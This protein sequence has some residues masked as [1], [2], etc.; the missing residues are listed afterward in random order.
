MIKK[1]KIVLP[2][3]CL[4]I[5]SGCEDLFVRFKNERYECKP[6][7]VNLNKIFIKNYDQGDEVDVEVGDYLYKFK[8]TYISDQKMYLVQ[9]AED[10]V[11]KIYRK[12]NKIEARMDNLILNVQCAKETLWKKVNK[13]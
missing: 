11:I 9:E 12:T 5:L 3:F 1:L 6:N 7:R 13:S 8:I 4:I 10:F 2:V